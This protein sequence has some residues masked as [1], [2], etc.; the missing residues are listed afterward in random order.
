MFRGNFNIDVKY[1][2]LCFSYIAIECGKLIQRAAVED[3]GLA[4]SNLSRH[5]NHHLRLQYNKTVTALILMFL[6]EIRLTAIVGAGNM[7]DTARCVKTGIDRRSQSF[8][9]L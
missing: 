6:H 1:S 8:N 5:G 2:K 3:A 4:E 9:L 7:N